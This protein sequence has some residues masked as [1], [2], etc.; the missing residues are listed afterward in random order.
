MQPVCD[1]FFDPTDP[2]R[3]P[4]VASLNRSVRAYV[5]DVRSYLLQLHDEGTPARR[6]NEERSDLFDRLIKK[7]FR[8]SE[9]G[10]HARSA[11]LDHRIAIL[12]VGGYGR[13]ELALA[14]DLDLL[15]L[16]RGK[17]NPYVETI[18]EAITYRLWD[19]NLAVACATRTIPDCI[20]MG[21]EDLSTM[22]G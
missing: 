22:T 4:D 14:S 20:R 18:A 5:D 6:I 15:I 12:A 10:Y 3:G 9:D 21:E 13:L 7:L 17:M 1:A 8:V 2:V 16:Y 19:A 11:R